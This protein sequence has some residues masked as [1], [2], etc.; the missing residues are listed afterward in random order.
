MLDTQLTTQL[1]QARALDR[2]TREAT[3]RR[4]HSVASFWDQN[5]ELLSE[6]WQEWESSVR[7]QLPALD[8]SLLDEQLRAA[9]E[10]AWDDPSTEGAVRDLWKPVVP[11]VYEAQFFDPKRIQELRTYLDAAVDAEIPMRPP[12]GIVLNRYG[13]MLDRRSTGYL[14]A[15]SFQDFYGRLMERYMRPISR[16]LFPE[17]VGYDSQTFG[18]SIQYQPGM[19][20]SIQPHSDA[21]ST[22][23]NINMNLPGE[24]FS[25]SGV[26]FYDYSTGRPS[27]FVFM[28][29]VAALHRGAVPHA[30]H[31]ITEG[32]RSNLVLWLY[33]EGMKIPHPGEQP[34]SLTARERWAASLA[35]FDRSVPF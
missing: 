7:E 18:F 6:A 22:T 1:A 35:P 26:D 14:A 5:A 19:D 3:L 4:D 33:G 11:G 15:P 29:G 9:V 12:Y 23:L 21:S 32:E 27:R 17:V 10:A 2:P 34:S 13:A 20:T 8:E 25:G 28:P 31:P 16:L 24:S 30:A